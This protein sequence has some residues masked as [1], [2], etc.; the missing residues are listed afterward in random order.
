MEL[1]KPY[2]PKEIEEKWYKIWEEKGYF[3]PQTDKNKTPFCIVIPPPNVTGSLHIGHAL[4]NTIQDIIIRYK[5]MQGYSTLWLP[6]TDHAG[7]PTQML[8]ERELAK[9]KKNRLDL[10]R[11]KFLDKV[12]E[13]KEKYGN[14]IIEQLKK[15]G[16]SCDWSRLRFTMDKEYSEAVITT[17]KKL[18]EKGYIYRGKRIINWC[19]KCR[20][21]VSDI[22]VVHKEQDGFLYYIKYPLVGE[23]DKYI[24]VATTRPET[25]LGDV[26]VAVNP[27]DERYAE[28]IGKYVILPIKEREVP[29][30][31]DEYVDMEFGTGALKITPSHDAQDFEIGRKHN[32]PSVQVIG[33]R[34][35]M[36]A[37]AGK[38]EGED[39]YLARQ[40]IVEELR[41][42]SLLEKIENY[43][44]SLG[45]HDRC[46]VIIEPLLSLQWFVK[47]KDL[48]QPSIQVVKEG[49]IK[50]IPER[51][52]SIYLQWMEN[53]KDW[54]ISR[55]IW[56]GHRLPVWYCLEMQNEKC[57]MKNGI[58]VSEIVP[59]KCPYCSSESLIQDED[60]LDTWFSSALWPH[61]TLGWPKETEDLK[62]FYPT[63][64]LSTARD[65]IY[66]W[67]AR[68]I[69]TGIEFMQ[70]I[71]FSEVFI[72]PTV[73]NF[74]GRRMSKSLGTGVDPLHLMEKYGTDA[75]RWGLIGQTS[76]T[77]DLK[78]QENTV[79]VGRNFCNK[80]YNAAKFVK[81]STSDTSLVENLDIL[82][83]DI[84]GRWILSRLSSVGD[85]VKKQLDDYE[86]QEVSRLLY[87]FVWGDFCDWYI[88]IAKYKLKI[89][90]KRPLTQQTLLY[91]FAQVLKM[92]HPFLPFIT[93]EV[94]NILFPQGGHLIIQPW[95]FSEEKYKDKEVEEK[96]RK[97]FE[98]IKGIRN[99]KQ[100]KNVVVEKNLKVF[101]KTEDKDIISLLKETREII[102]H[103]A[104][105]Q[106]IKIVEEIPPSA[107][108]CTVE[109]V[110]LTLS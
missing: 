74:E 62:Y 92:L 105:V 60:V 52:A 104:R 17:F 73:L 56:W 86:F 75:T 22:E 71:P 55:Q 61:A 18:Y 69:I 12:W 77:Q 98:I 30:I 21:A 47:M 110:E 101:F 72:H 24:V 38:Y 50:F 88:E 3:T 66:L 82:S 37:E 94:W 1:N 31:S 45:Y 26:A 10:G 13:W 107:L 46:N 51:F 63:S 70:D 76:K 39:R 89:E 27:K 29:V 91:V 32:L 80:I 99:L 78:F 36:T 85:E 58:I 40:K 4:N 14:I 67:V 8:V 11:E 43:T 25:M 79:V 83:S 93:E 34:G 64:V 23:K 81:A 48:A 87:S 106:E 95:Y 7:I 41:Q 84:S 19:C 57:K 49:K 100:K 54:C 44:L 33:P 15:L 109:N 9:E 65:I 97:T 96:M 53:I 16:C 35:K 59:Q 20:T 103:L 42:L 5:R 6:G 28:M 102:L 68:M 108:S 2:S 90:E